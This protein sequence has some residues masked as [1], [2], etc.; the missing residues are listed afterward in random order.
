M[1]QTMYVPKWWP[2]TLNE[3][4]AGHWAIAHKLKQECAQMIAGYWLAHNGQR[5]TTHR[6]VH[7]HLIAP[8]G[9]RLPDRDAWW[10]A[11]LDAL[12]QC[13]ALVDD[14][15][16]YCTP[17]SVTYSRSDDTW[18]VMITLEDLV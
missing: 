5:A 12:V 16:R 18:G 14:S 11:T 15:P 1:K 9:Q 17:G 4:F 7:L 6:K 8:K 13:G 10:K 3:L 2:P